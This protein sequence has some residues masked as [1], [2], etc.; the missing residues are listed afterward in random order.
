[1][2][3]SFKLLKW[4]IGQGRKHDIENLLQNFIFPEEKPFH[5]IQLQEKYVRS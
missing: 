5:K 3:S 4:E 2:N 1:M